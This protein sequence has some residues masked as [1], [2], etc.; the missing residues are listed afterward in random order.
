MKI[1]RQQ[2]PFHLKNSEA[3]IPGQKF[4]CNFSFGVWH[5]SKKSVVVNKKPN[6][7]KI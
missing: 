7:L 6:D 5:K 2:L 3:Q 4:A 1:L